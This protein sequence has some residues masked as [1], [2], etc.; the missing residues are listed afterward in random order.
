MIKDPAIDEIRAVR[1][2]ISEE[3]GHDSDRL[4]DYLIERQKKSAKK[5]QYRFIGA[6]DSYIENWLKSA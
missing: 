5:R 1:H 3:F 6:E 4:I 2:Q